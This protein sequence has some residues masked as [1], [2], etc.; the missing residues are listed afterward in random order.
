MGFEAQPGKI[1]IVQEDIDDPNGIRETRSL[2]GD[3]RLE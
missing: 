3:R 1:Q 2:G